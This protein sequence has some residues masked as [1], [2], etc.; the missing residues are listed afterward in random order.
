MFSMNAQSGRKGN[1]KSMA[2]PSTQQ[3]MWEWMD[4]IWGFA[5]GAVGA[6]AGMVAWVNPRFKDMDEQIDALNARMNEK[7]DILHGRITTVEKLVVQL[8][9]NHESTM[10]LYN[11]VSD[12]IKD[13]NKKTDDQTKIL[14]E[15]VGGLNAIQNQRRENK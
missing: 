7:A 5:M 10:L 14:H 15:V 13:L 6:V 9:G 2:D 1:G 8:E 11:A 4:W 3:A 12:G